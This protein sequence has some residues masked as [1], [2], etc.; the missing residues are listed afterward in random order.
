MGAPRQQKVRR[1]DKRR[2]QELK[3]FLRICF[4]LTDHLTFAELAVT[5]ELSLGTLYKLA[6]EDV[7]LHM[8]VGTLYAIAEAAGLNIAYLDPKQGKFKLVL[9]EDRVIMKDDRK[10]VA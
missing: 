9:K 4:H 3:L 8:R 7:T 10:R 6:A 1:G 5:S 2:L